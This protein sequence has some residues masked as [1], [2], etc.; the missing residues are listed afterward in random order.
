MPGKRLR[1][2]F[3]QEHRLFTISMPS[4]AG[5]VAGVGP[6]RLLRPAYAPHQGPVRLL[7]V[8]DDRRPGGDVAQQGVPYPPGGG[9]P[10]AADDCHHVLGRRAR[11]RGSSSYSFPVRPRGRPPGMSPNI[12]GGAAARANLCWR[13]QPYHGATGRGAAE[14]NHHPFGLLVDFQISLGK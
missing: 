13:E 7:P 8:V 9:L 5:G 2:R 4:K 3:I 14:G 6:V 10:V 11:R 12:E 1:R